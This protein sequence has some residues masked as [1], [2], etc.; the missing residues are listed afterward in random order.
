MKS[1][2]ILNIVQIYVVLIVVVIFP[3]ILVFATKRILIASGLFRLHRDGRHV[4]IE[5][6]LFIVVRGKE[7]R[8]QIL[9]P[10]VF[11]FV[12]GRMIDDNK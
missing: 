1:C 12:C 10:N 8:I 9:P 7:L 11:L 5:R 3:K 6:R 2:T 4:I